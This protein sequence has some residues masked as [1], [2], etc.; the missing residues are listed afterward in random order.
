MI[1]PTLW[2][3]LS[4]LGYLPEFIMLKQ[5]HQDMNVCFNFNDSLSEPINNGVKES[6]IQAPT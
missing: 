1:M 4:K 3:I 6:D 5:L 2:N